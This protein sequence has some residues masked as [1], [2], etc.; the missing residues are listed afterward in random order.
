MF[1]L[2]SRAALLATL[3]ALGGA[4]AGVAWG[5]TPV[6]KTA[7]SREVGS[8]VAMVGVAL[9]GWRS[10]QTVARDQCVSPLRKSE[11]VHV[12][13]S[14]RLYPKHGA[15]I[16]IVGLVE[17]ALPASTAAQRVVAQFEQRTSISCVAALTRSQLAAANPGR[18]TTVKVRPTPSAVLGFR[19]VHG[20]V[21][22]VSVHGYTAVDY[23]HLLTQDAQDPRLI[24]NLVLASP[25]PQPFSAALARRLLAACSHRA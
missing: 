14:W 12:F 4:I 1:V 10:S 8:R 15:S 25:K 20:Y 18:I 21:I 5:S 3:V 24:C 13:R 9:R 6:S 11:I 16:F 2:R 7:L 17:A 23:D 19:G 22:E